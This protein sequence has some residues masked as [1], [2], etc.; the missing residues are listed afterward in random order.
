MSEWSSV[1]RAMPMPSCLSCDAH[2][3]RRA[4]ALAEARAGNNSPARIAMMAI[5]T[6]N[7]ISVKPPLAVHEDDFPLFVDRIFFT[8]RRRRHFQVTQGNK[9]VKITVKLSAGHGVVEFAGKVHQ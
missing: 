9:F 1:K 3:V 4:L 7:S 6:S 2:W 5:T 8:G